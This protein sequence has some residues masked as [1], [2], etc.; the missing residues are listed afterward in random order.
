MKKMLMD[1]GHFVD[2][3]TLVLEHYHGQIDVLYLRDHV[4]PPSNTDMFYGFHV[5]VAMARLS[6]SG[7]CKQNVVDE[8]SMAKNC[9]RENPIQIQNYPQSSFRPRN[10]CG[11]GN[12]F[13]LHN[14]F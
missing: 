5:K 2:D 14:M 7:M 13:F 1:H 12:M 9:W 3:L 11:K 4:Y 6:N 10:P 8:H